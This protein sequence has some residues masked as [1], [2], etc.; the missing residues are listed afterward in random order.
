MDPIHW[1]F[2]W[3]ITRRWYRGKKHIGLNRTMYHSILGR[4]Y[5]L[6]KN[7]QILSSNQSF[8]DS[9]NQLQV[10][11]LFLALS[12]PNLKKKHEPKNL[13]FCSRT[14]RPQRKLCKINSSWFFY[15]DYS[16]WSTMTNPG[17]IRNSACFC[18]FPKIFSS[19][20]LSCQA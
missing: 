14:W 2:M 17:N 10:S 15:L 4:I 9:V 18:I 12:S 5:R 7:V 19:P 11:S 1:H 6:V 3:A 16:F 20:S 13:A 8:V